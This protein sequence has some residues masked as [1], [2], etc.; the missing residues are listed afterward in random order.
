MRW[1]RLLPIQSYLRDFTWNAP[2]CTHFK[3][4]HS[5]MFRQ[6]VNN[7]AILK[8]KRFLNICRLLYQWGEGSTVKNVEFIEL[9][10]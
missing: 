6:N 10:E 7:D 5:C 8:W 1:R 4:A 3:L 9:R 2:E